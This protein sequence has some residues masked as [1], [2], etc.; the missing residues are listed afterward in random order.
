[1]DISSCSLSDVKQMQKIAV[2]SYF[3]MIKYFI[4]NVS[5]VIVM[6]DLRFFQYQNFEIFVSST[7]FSPPLKK[8]NYIVTNYS[9]PMMPLPINF[10]YYRRGNNC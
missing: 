1:M 2:L 10:H 4:N 6:L 9:Q 5:V 3:S 8:L 7:S